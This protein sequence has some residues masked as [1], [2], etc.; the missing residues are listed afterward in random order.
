MR[1]KSL[2][3]FYSF[4][5]KTDPDAPTGN[6]IARITVGGVTFEKLLKIETV[7]PNRLKINLDFGPDIQSISGG[8]INTELTS[9]WLHGAIARNLKSDVN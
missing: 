7:M 3:G 2:N 6:W 8:E 1:K 9:T 5:T 4:H